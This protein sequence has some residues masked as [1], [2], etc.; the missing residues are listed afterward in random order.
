MYLNFHSGIGRTVNGPEHREPCGRSLEGKA[1]CRTY[2]KATCREQD[3]L[4][5]PHKNTA[6]PTGCQLQARGFAGF[7]EELFPLAAN[8][9]FV[10]AIMTRVII[11]NIAPPEFPVLIQVC[12]TLVYPVATH[13]AIAQKSTPLRMSWRDMLA[14]IEIILATD[15]DPPRGIS[16]KINSCR[17]YFNMYN[18]LIHREGL[19]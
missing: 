9:A 18:L 15:V 12:R 17:H 3:L 4:E 14:R 19:G 1:F 7:I 8:V 11:R 6:M 5:P 13:P 2:G 16:G 10:T